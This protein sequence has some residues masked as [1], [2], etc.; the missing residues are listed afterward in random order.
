MFDYITSKR[1]VLHIKSLIDNC[2]MIL[3]DVI[4]W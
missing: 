1:R 4:L 3:K 2:L